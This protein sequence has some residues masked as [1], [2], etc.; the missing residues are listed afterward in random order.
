MCFHFSH[1][2]SLFTCVFTFRM[3]FH[4]SHVFSLFTCVFTFHMC[5]HFLHVFS[6]FTCVFTFYMCFHFSHVFSLFTCVFTF[7]MCFHFSHVISSMEKMEMHFWHEFDILINFVLVLLGEF[8]ITAKEFPSF[9]FF[10]N[11]RNRKKPTKIFKLKVE[12]VSSNFNFDNSERIS[13]VFVLFKL[14]KSQKTNQNF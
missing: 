5:F 2:F 8:L 9:S 11:F 6:L 3:C 14:Q 13:V 7:Y 1:V 12:F 4:F 10:S